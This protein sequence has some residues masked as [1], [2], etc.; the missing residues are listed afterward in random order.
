MVAH[1]A[2]V[3]AFKSSQESCLTEPYLH[4]EHLATRFHSAVL[5]GELILPD[6]GPAVLVPGVGHHVEIWRP[7]LKLP[8]PVNN[9]GEGCAHQER[10]L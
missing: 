4:A 2:T 3:K 6:D 5:I 7:H 1:I 8:L 9:G 10:P